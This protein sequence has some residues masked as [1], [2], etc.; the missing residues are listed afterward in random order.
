M[1]AGRGSQPSKREGGREG[2]R[3]ERMKERT[4]GQPARRTR[5]PLALA[6]CPE[7]QLVG[8]ADVSWTFSR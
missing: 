2:G 7:G 5:K 1:Q 4:E 3:S 8:Q 6:A